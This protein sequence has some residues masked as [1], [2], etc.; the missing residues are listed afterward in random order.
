MTT[1]IL[2]GKKSPTP[3]VLCVSI[4]DRK[5][6]T[7]MAD[8][9]HSIVPPTSCSPAQPSFIFL[10]RLASRLAVDLLI[11][12]LKHA[13]GKAGWINKMNHT[14][15]CNNSLREGSG[16]DGWQHTGQRTPW[17]TGDTDKWLK[18]DW[19]E[20]RWEMWLTGLEKH[21]AHWIKWAEPTFSAPRAGLCNY[22]H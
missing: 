3:F 12:P 22:L 4:K 21:A 10:R 19:V 2:P 7:T 15:A 8:K 5:P 18:W 17:S 9:P 16:D 13:R 20:G 11:V 6:R 1:S 14:I